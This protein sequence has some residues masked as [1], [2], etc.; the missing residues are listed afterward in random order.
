MHSVVCHSLSIPFN[1]VQST[2]ALFRSVFDLKEQIPDLALP[3]KLE[4]LVVLLVDQFGSLSPV[5]Y[6][7]STRGQCC[8]VDSFL[9]KSHLGHGP[10]CS[11]LTFAFDLSN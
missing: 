11:N 8:L 7:Y 10:L 2:L 9:G 5:D 3:R 4:L 1:A 6:G